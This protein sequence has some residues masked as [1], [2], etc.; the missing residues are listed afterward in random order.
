VERDAQEWLGEYVGKIAS[1]RYP[2]EG[3]DSMANKFANVEISHGNVPRN[4]GEHYLLLSH[5][6]AGGVVGMKSG[7]R[8]G[9]MTHE[10]GS[11]TVNRDGRCRIA[12]LNDLSLS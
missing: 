11:A 2:G 5:S 3:D 4:R 7:W 10:T 1:R 8:L 12:H 6:N 9:R